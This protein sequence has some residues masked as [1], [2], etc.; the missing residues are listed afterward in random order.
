M[1]LGLV[2]NT[3]LIFFVDMWY[4]KSLNTRDQHWVQIQRNNHIPDGWRLGD[5][6]LYENAQIKNAQSMQKK[7]RVD[8]V[9]MSPFRPSTCPIIK[10]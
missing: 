4:T 2:H 8:A 7:A 3:R 1:Q 9:F 5:K 6:K 10:L